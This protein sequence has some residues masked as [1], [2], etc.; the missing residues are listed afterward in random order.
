MAIQRDDD[1]EG[2]AAVIS[3]GASGIG[4][5]L[6]VAY[7]RSGAHS[8]VN[9]RTAELPAPQLSM[10]FRSHGCNRVRHESFRFDK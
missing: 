3:G 7:A 6:A 8:V 10:A 2:K 4:Q 1:L 5:A 9:R